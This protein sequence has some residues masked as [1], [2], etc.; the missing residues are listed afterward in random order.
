MRRLGGYAGAAAAGGRS[1]RR[2]RW[3]PAFLAAAVVAAVSLAAGCAAGVRQAPQAVS[4]ASYQV[5]AG[6]ADATV[7]HLRGGDQLVIPRGALKAGSTV[8]AVYGRAPAGSW[9]GTQPVSL[10][11]HF[12]VSPE[13]R[14]RKPLL[15]D[16]YL[17][18]QADLDAAAFGYYRVS[19]LDTR[20][21]RWVEVPSSY[22]PATR[23]LVTELWHFSW[24]SKVHKA[25]TVAE[26]AAKCLTESL[27]PGAVQAARKFLKCLIKEGLTDLNSAI[28][29]RIL[30]DL[31][32][33]SCWGALQTDGIVAAPG[34]PG[35]VITAVLAGIMTESACIGDAGS[36]GIAAPTVSKVSPALGP[37][38]GGTTVTIIGWMFATATSVTFGGRPAASFTI[39]LNSN[40]T[41]T[42][43]APAG[44][45]GTVNVRVADGGGVSRVTRADPKIEPVLGARQRTLAVA[46]WP[47]PAGG[48]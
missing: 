5:R 36:G 10:P 8:R 7:L 34:G 41:I 20:T 38:S 12:I 15:L 9:D 6:Q 21:H 4:P 35:A 11:V 16:S 33:K 18:G 2:K 14:F 27:A 31:L 43:I 25:Q 29:T 46:G 23:M 24:W 44:T 1:I 45:A 19:T 39:G 22:D 32:P 28:E 13:Q 48:R 42:A 3:R 40:D 47:G 30:S 17:G 37:A 26:I